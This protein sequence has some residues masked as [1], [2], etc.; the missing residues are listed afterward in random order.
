MEQ[1]TVGDD[2][3]A[4][5]VENI[6]DGHIVVHGLD[7]SGDG[8]YADSDADLLQG[9]EAGCGLNRWSQ[10]PLRT[11]VMVCRGRSLV[12]SCRCHRGRAVWLGAYDLRHVPSVRSPNDASP[13]P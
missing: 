8:T 1:V 3:P 6:T 2:I 11:S 5:V 9:N 13:M 12:A 7:T 10:Q 4:D